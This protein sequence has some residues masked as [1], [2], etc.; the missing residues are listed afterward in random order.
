MK[1]QKTT[2]E[3]EH[4]QFRRTFEDTIRNQRDLK[5][6]IFEKLYDNK[7]VH[8]SKENYFLSMIARSF[9]SQ[10]NW[11]QVY[12]ED[13]NTRIPLGPVH[14]FAI[15][16]SRIRTNKVKIKRFR[17][18]KTVPLKELWQILYDELPYIFPGALE[19]ALKMSGKGNKDRKT[20]PFSFDGGPI[21]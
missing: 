12:Y 6:F 10:G 15:K 5:A 16:L 4:F 1:Q 19:E 3:D 2:E 20:V 21:D 9:L 17:F 13:G 14:T 8:T 18:E 7:G 11:R